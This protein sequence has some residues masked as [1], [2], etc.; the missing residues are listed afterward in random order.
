MAKNK[1]GKT[2]QADIVHATAAV[3]LSAQAKAAKTVD[4]LK[5]VVLLMLKRMGL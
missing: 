2:K 4:D 3:T 1:T 5:A